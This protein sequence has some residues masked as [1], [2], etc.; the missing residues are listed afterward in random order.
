MAI[1]HSIEAYRPHTPTHG[2][3]ALQSRASFPQEIGKKERPHLAVVSGSNMHQELGNTGEALN[4]HVC[5]LVQEV[6]VVKQT[7]QKRSSIGEKDA[8]PW[9]YLRGTG[10]FIPTQVNS[11]LKDIQ[12]ELQKGKSFKEALDI[13]SVKI[14]EDIKGFEDEYL[15]QLAALCWNIGWKDAAGT[16][17]LYGID[18][19]GMFLEDLTERQEREGALYDTWFTDKPEEGKKGIESW[20]RTAPEGSKVLLVSPKGWSGYE[21]FTYPQTQIYYVEVGKGNTLKSFTLRYDVSIEKNEE[22]QK[23]LGIMVPSVRNERDRIKQMLG[24]PIF[25]APDGSSINQDGSATNTLGTRKVCSPE[26]VIDLMQSVKGSD[27]AYA[28]DKFGARTFGD[29]REVIKNPQKFLTRHPGSE[30][31]VETF[32]EYVSWEFSQGHDEKETRQNLEIALALVIVQLKHLYFGSATAEA[33][34][35]VPTQSV[36]TSRPY[37]AGG[38][39]QNNLNYEQEL[40][41][42]RKLPGCAGTQDK[43]KSRKNS[44]GGSREVESSASSL[45]I[46]EKPCPGCGQLIFASMDDCKIICPNEGCPFSF[47]GREGKSVSEQQ[48]EKQEIKE[49]PKKEEPKP[50]KVVQKKKPETKKQD[51]LKERRGKEPEVKAA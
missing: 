26:D 40:E 28:D 37:G 31:L 11:F 33:V 34:G 41:D 19:N 21:G 50:E 27:I 36:H 45:M 48:E 12:A 25:I 39:F 32:R 17:K 10:F 3:L 14:R 1:I 9:Y 7:E 51:G 29:M 15:K 44:M 5:S 20:L 24:T 49:A 4:P 16:N 35:H 8:E 18:Y 22:L 46:K 30:K 43:N 2:A 23:K 38:I 13:S 6:A 47:S 42:I